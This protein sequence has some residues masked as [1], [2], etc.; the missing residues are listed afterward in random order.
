M[1]IQCCTKSPRYE[2]WWTKE[3]KEYLHRCQ[4]YESR[5]QSLSSLLEQHKLWTE[6]P[7]KTHMPTP[8]PPK[9]WHLEWDLWEVIQFILGHEGRAPWFDECP[10]RKREERQDWSLL[11]CGRRTLR[12]I[13]KPGRR[14]S[15]G[16]ESVGALILAFRSL[17]LWETV[18]D[19]R[20]QAYA[21]SL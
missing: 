6:C 17:A 4:I 20:G 19:L 11:L 9:W 5:S 21:I 2:I 18:W 12:I 14:F 8:K 13:C 7:L 16:E 1:V 15:P 3:G 10:Y